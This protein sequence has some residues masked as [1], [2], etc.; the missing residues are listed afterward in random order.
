MALEDELKARTLALVSQQM[1]NWVVEIQKRIV[2][3]QANLVGA[4]DELQ[5][6]VARYDEKIDEGSIGS[7]ID[8]VIAA[9]PVAAGMRTAAR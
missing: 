1:A 4:L 9:N 5:E 6:N 3:H 7:A 2:E 8:E